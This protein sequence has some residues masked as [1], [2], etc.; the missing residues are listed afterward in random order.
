MSSNT[1]RPHV[2]GHLGSLNRVVSRGAWFYL[3][4]I[5]VAACLSAAMIQ[6]V[7][8]LGASGVNSDHPRARALVVCV[9]LVSLSLAPYAVWAS[10]WNIP[11]HTQLAFA[12]VAYVIP[13][14]LLG[15]LDEADPTVVGLY[16]KIVVLGAAA[17]FV[18]VLLGAPIA[19][20]A[21]WRPASDFVRRSAINA[22]SVAPKR[23]AL[24]SAACLA[25]MLFSFA[26]MGFIPA[27]SADPFSAKFFR[28]AYAEAY[29]PIA[30]IYRFSTTILALLLPQ[31][32]VYALQR[33]QFV[34][35]LLLG[36][37]LIVMLLSLQRGPAISGVLLAV[38]VVLAMKGRGM[39]LYILG[40]AG[41]YFAGSVVYEIL[42]QFGFQAFANANTNSAGLLGRAA[43]GA[44]DVSDQMTFL[45]YWLARPEFTNGLTFVGGLIPGNFHWNPSVW[46]LAVINP[47]QEVSAVVSG[48]LRLPAPLWGFVS[49]GWLGVVGVS[50]ISGVL[51]GLITRIARTLIP[52][53]NVAGS[54]M[55]LTLYLAIQEVVPAFYRLGYLSIVALAVLMYVYFWRSDG[56]EQAVRPK[57]DDTC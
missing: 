29:G 54:L 34:W 43:A 51:T 39:W 2:N 37:A 14:G 17:F 6:V 4:A 50:L 21:C 22:E 28:G 53:S 24:L 44:P 8:V 16:A 7:D 33:S 1:T 10:R 38:G 47:G 12:L 35:K 26:V 27:L 46:S 20:L 32:T 57:Q 19:G 48:G 36:G 52:S 55:L 42:A 9:A 56:T 3:A 41:V 5:A 30:P 31:L 25:G 15:T 13:I 49:F 11:A 40:L 23:I 18:G 45:T